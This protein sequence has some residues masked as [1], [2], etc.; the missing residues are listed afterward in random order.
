MLKSR[1]SLL[2]LVLFNSLAENKNANIHMERC[3]FESSKREHL[4]I[5]VLYKS[6]N[7]CK[8]LRLVQGHN[9]YKARVLLLKYIASYCLLY[10]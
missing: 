3:T 8:L 6:S 10:A 7:A 9:L 1:L 4:G 5:A 2:I